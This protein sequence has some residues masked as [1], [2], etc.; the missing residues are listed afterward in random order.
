VWVEDLHADNQNHPASTEDSESFRLVSIDGT[1]VLGAF[2]SESL[3]LFDK[4]AAKS[5]MASV[6]VVFAMFFV[7]VYLFV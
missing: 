3:E 6:F 4:T 2:P 5:V 1:R 7:M